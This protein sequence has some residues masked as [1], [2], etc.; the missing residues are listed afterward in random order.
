MRGHSS[1][2]PCKA[3][4]HN[5]NLLQFFLNV[6]EFGMAVQETCEA[7]NI[8]SYQMR[9]SFGTHVAEPGRVTLN[10]KVPS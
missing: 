7:V 6:V 10:D 1:V 4:T 3:A 8:T 2:S 5:Q 9:R